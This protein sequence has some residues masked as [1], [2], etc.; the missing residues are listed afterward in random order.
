M[1][2]KV[3]KNPLKVISTLHLPHSVIENKL[4]ERNFHCF[5]ARNTEKVQKYPITFLQWKH[6]HSFHISVKFMYCV[7]EAVK[8]CHITSQVL[9]WL[10][11]KSAFTVWI[12]VCIVSI[13]C[14]VC[15]ALHILMVGIVKLYNLVVILKFGWNWENLWNSVEFVVWSERL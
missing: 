11:W 2:L 4:V 15:I 12:V 3:E 9:N 10:C 13:L 1:A 6:P 5:I 7:C 14:T 8:K